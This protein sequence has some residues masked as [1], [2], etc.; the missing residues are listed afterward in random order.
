MGSGL[1]CVGDRILHTTCCSW[2]MGRGLHLAVH[3]RKKRSLRHT[4]R[5]PHISRFLRDVGSKRILTFLAGWSKRPD[6]GRSTSHISQ[7]T[8]DMGH[9]ELWHGKAKSPECPGHRVGSTI[10][11]RASPG[12]DRD[13]PSSTR[14]GIA[15]TPSPSRRCLRSSRS[16][17]LP[18][19][20]QIP[21]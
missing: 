10:P 19:K 14:S 5:V 1:Q 11:G 21:S 6:Q 20:A 17:E 15:C 12:E 2:A 16:P 13:P 4:V 8:R 7:K 18:H 9:P 3:A